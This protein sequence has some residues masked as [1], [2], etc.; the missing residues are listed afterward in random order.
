MPARSRTIDDRKVGPPDT[1]FKTLDVAADKPEEQA[2]LGDAQSRKMNDL[3]SELREISGQVNRMMSQ[4][5]RAIHRLGEHT[6]AAE[7]L[8]R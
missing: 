1:A 3:V 4:V 7:A 5:D 2:S 6:H 8:K